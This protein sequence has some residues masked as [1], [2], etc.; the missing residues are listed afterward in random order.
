MTEVIRRRDPLSVIGDSH[1]RIR[2][3]EATPSTGGGSSGDC[4]DCV[5]NP[6][7]LNLGDIPIT[8]VQA[9]CLAGYG[10]VGGQ[11]NNLTGGLNCDNDPFT[12]TETVIAGT[13]GVGDISLDGQVLIPQ[14]RIVAAFTGGWVNV[15]ASL[16]GMFQFTFV[17]E[18]P[19]PSTYDSGWVDGDGAW[20][21]GCATLELSGG[22]TPLN[23]FG[24]C[25]TGSVTVRYRFVDEDTGE[26]RGALDDLPQ[27]ET[28]GDTLHFN[29]TTHEFVVG[30]R[31]VPARAMSTFM[32]G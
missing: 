26:F 19:A 3:I 5:L 20:G 11:V 31:S 23:F 6:Y 7:T 30:P 10:L 4:P 21:G 15:T 13:A 25:V 2:R 29:S 16:G 24:T 32:G 8:P 12:W 27:G 1:R 17:P 14:F 18:Q 28:Y 9:A 22:V